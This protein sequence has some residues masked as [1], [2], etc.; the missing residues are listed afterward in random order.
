MKILLLGKNGQL[1][2]ELQRSLAVLGQV[3]ALDRHPHNGWCGDLADLDG[4][5][6]TIRGLRPDVVVNAAAYTQVDLAEDH[7][8]QATLINASAPQALA[9]ELSKTGGWLVHYSTDYVFDGTGTLPWRETDPA[10]PLN[11]YGRSKRLGEKWIVE[12]G[13]QHLIFRTSRVFGEHGN[14]F[15]KT[16]L[17]LGRDRER[18]SVVNDQIGAPTGAELL[19]DVTAHALRIAV[20]HPDKAGLYHLAAAG[21]VSWYDFAR[22][23]FQHV[24]E[25]GPKVSL[26][27]TLNPRAGSYLKVKEVEPIPSSAYAAAAKR[28]LNSRLDTTKIQKT[29][30]IHLPEWQDGVRRM[31]D[32]IIL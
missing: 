18:L 10:H 32:E 11:E 9:Q 19:A 7:A 6:A 23:I 1:G 12:S 30:S 25:Y 31:L 8:A 14:N 20:N 13:C 28:P 29:F 5:R 26:R 16:M 17:R 2:W 21:E 22:F 4:L 15:V 24:R 3:I 27:D